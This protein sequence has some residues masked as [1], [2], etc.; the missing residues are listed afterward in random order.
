M[1]AHGLSQALRG[2]RRDPWL[3]ALMIAALALGTGVFGIARGGRAML[4][5]DPM[6]GARDLFHVEIDRGVRFPDHLHDGKAC[7]LS[8]FHELTVSLGDALALLGTGLTRREGATFSA[9]VV[10]DTPAGPEDARA[11][12]SMADISSMFGQEILDG[13][14]FSATEVDAIVIDA[15]LAERWF[16][17]ARAV[18]R[19]VTIAGKRFTISGVAAYDEARLRPQDFPWLP[20]PAVHLPFEAHR[21]LRAPPVFPAADRRGEPRFVHVWVEL[22]GEAGREAYLA[23]AARAARTEGVTLRPLADWIR[24]NTLVDAAYVLL[25]RIGYV[26]LVA[27]CFGLMRLLLARLRARSAEIGV[28]RALGASRRSI[29]VQHVLEAALLG[30]AGGVAALPIAAAGL[31]ILSSSLPGSWVAFALDLEQALAA[32]AASVGTALIAGAYAA[33]RA[34]R[35]TVAEALSRT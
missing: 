17:G 10:V 3:S 31:D 5:R 30:L 18:G 6:P 25:E 4:S 26:A 28:R 14:T 24:M 27:S 23:A 12:F 32:V 34:G 33:W 22:G 2:V 13:R 19:E 15:P 7:L 29:F 8:Q 9:Q 35:V 20:T 21:E 11:R 16:P 1:I